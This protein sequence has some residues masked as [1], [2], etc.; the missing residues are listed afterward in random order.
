MNK[1]LTLFL[2]C[3]LW[4]VC[5]RDAHSKPAVA[6]NKRS[7]EKATSEE[8]SVL[9]DTGMLSLKMAGIISIQDLL[10]QR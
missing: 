2:V 10:S 6:E 3:P 8:I 7:Q 4:M 5:C 9:P 1:F